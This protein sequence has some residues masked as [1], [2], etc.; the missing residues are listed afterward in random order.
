MIRT[1]QTFKN[2]YHKRCPGCCSGLR[3]LEQ[4]AVAT[5]YQR[6]SRR[7]FTAWSLHAKHNAALRQRLRT[8]VYRMLMGRLAS[9]F[10]TWRSIGS[11]LA[12]ERRLVHTAVARLRLR[13]R[14]MLRLIS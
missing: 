12:H 9:A 4:G 14:L 8:V 7:A 13:V 6:H 1:L 10:A 3:R 11:Q 5:L 2:S